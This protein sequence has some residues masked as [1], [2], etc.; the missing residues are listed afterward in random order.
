MS[1]DWVET[2]NIIRSNNG[3]SWRKSG[4]FSFNVWIPMFYRLSRRSWTASF[5]KALFQ[6]E[7]FYSV[8]GEL[9]FTSSPLLPKQCFRKLVSAT[10]SFARKLRKKIISFLSLLWSNYI[11][12][13]KSLLS[14]RLF[15]RPQSNIWSC[16]SSPNEVQMVLTARRASSSSS[17]MANM[18]WNTAISFIANRSQWEVE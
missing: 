11:N 5:F 9:L 7:I 12:L 1:R 6:I 2:S 10:Q 3:S 16:W 14:N 8:I 17:W 18:S 13:S 4:I 15:A